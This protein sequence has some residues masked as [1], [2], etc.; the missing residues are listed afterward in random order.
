M[1]SWLFIILCCFLPIQA[2]ADI[3]KAPDDEFRRLLKEAIESDLGFIDK[4]D[5]KV[6][7]FDM[8]SRLAKRAKHIPAKERM[9]LLK[10]VHREATKSGLDPQLVLAVIDTESG[11]DHYALFNFQKP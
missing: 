11:F 9:A 8:S 7:L 3:H 1:Y 2:F 6:W 5:A 10:A 4:F